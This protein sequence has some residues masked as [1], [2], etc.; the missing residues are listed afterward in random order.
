MRTISK[1]R[2]IQ[3]LLILL[4]FGKSTNA[5][6]RN[7]DDAETNE[8]AIHQHNYEEERTSETSDDHRVKG[9]E[10]LPRKINSD[11][12]IFQRGK[13][14]SQKYDHLPAAIKPVN[15]KKK[16]IIIKI[17][18]SHKKSL[19]RHHILEEKQF[20]NPRLDDIQEFHT[21]EE[22]HEHLDE[23]P[24]QNG[25]DKFPI[26]VNQPTEP[27]ET[28]DV[29]VDKQ[30]EDPHTQETQHFHSEEGKHDKSKKIKIKHHHHHHHHNH[31]KEII[32]KVPEPYPVE[33]VVHV[34]VEKIVEKIVHVPKP[35]PVEKIVEKVVKIPVEKIVHVPKPY[36]VE[37]IVEKKV[38][39]PVEKL[40]HV[41]VEK[42]V[43]KKVPYPVEKIVHVPIEK[44]VEKIV[45][46]PK[47]YPVEKVVEKIVH[48]PVEKIIE[49]KVPVTVEK[50]VPYPVEKIVHI[51]IEKIVEKIVHVPQPYPVE[52][53][54]NKFIPVPKPYAVVKAIPYPVEVKVPYQIEKPVPYAVE[55]Q[56]PVPYKVEIEKKVPVYIHSKEPYKYVHPHDAHVELD[57]HSSDTHIHE[58]H[59]SH[60]ED[61]GQHQH[62]VEPY[63]GQTGHD[64]SVF[65]S[66]HK[67]SVTS[68]KQELIH[69]PNHQQAHNYNYNQKNQNSPNNRQHSAQE[70][71]RVEVTL[72]PPEVKADSEFRIHVP[73][74]EPA[75]SAPQPQFAIPPSSDSSLDLLPQASTN[76][77]H[78]TQLQPIALP[79]QFIHYQPIQY[80][81][82]IGFA[83][84]RSSQYK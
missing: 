10:R 17:H 15:R 40:V 29:P 16:H 60:Q 30:L 27:A 59:S 82:P 28:Y 58:D 9:M 25:E 32:K 48:V 74:E 11:Q 21:F 80:Q 14:G 4:L 78:L 67:P 12:N 18:P 1:R 54:V 5:K 26:E 2:G 66:N 3:V 62:D 51:P 65:P 44:I 52:K 71:K 84:N 79:L 43:E 61:Y 37:K 46:I 49:K 75:G 39:Y 76:S 20:H 77:V 68:Y 81:Q 55:K 63:H 23:K 56:V 24:E 70:T 6:R 53:V 42:I 35:Y 41:P 33:K 7:S 22:T 47:P 19:Q 72:A 31:V 83:L 34:P 69:K 13:R 36:P 50:K 73:D 8:Y 45:H 57:E 64:L 38:P